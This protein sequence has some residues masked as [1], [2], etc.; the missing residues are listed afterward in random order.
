MTNPKVHPVAGDLANHNSDLSNNSEIPPQPRYADAAE[1]S[2]QAGHSL[3]TP[4]STVS[5]MFGGGILGLIGGV[6][7]SAVTAGSSAWAVVGLF[8][9]LAAGPLFTRVVSCCCFATSDVIYAC[10]PRSEAPPKTLSEADLPP[11]SPDHQIPT[12]IA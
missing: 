6:V 9:G 4:C 7:A 8:G 3:R 2:D 1:W 12:G 11:G 5:S 10:S